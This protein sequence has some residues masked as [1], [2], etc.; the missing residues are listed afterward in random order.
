[1]ANDLGI[2]EQ[3]LMADDGDTHVT[4]S[5]WASQ[6]GSGKTMLR[7][8]IFPVPA[9]L[10]QTIGDPLAALARKLLEEYELAGDSQSWK[11]TKAGDESFGSGPK[12]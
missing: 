9:E 8:D 6:N 10:A 3:I 7:L 5:Y 1:M 4:I 2:G 11:N 12:H